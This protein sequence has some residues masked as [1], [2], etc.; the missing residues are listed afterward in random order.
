MNRNHNYNNDHNRRCHRLV[1]W[2]LGSRDWSL[3]IFRAIDPIGDVLYVTHRNPMGLIDLL[4][5]QVSAG[6]HIEVLFARNDPIH[7][8]CDRNAIQFAIE[9]FL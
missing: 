1:K 2:A 5:T 3:G 7:G 9:A 6:K 8:C 4:A